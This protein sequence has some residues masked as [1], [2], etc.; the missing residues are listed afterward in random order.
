M[1]T[2][3]GTDGDTTGALVTNI[4]TAEQLT[5]LIQPATDSVDGSLSHLDKAY[6]D[7]LA[8]S[9]AGDALANGLVIST[10]QTPIV[11]FTTTSTTDVV[12]PAIPGKL[13]HLMEARIEF[14]T[15]NASLTGNFVYD[16]TQNDTSILDQTQ[17]VL[18]GV[19]NGVTPPSTVNSTARVSAIQEVDVSVH[20]HQLKIITPAVGSG[21]TDCTGRLVI[22]G[23]F[24]A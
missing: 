11:D 7:A 19:A 8:A 16:I 4:T 5:A 24:D 18:F 1:P 9:I 21:L 12:M 15:R 23:Y 10:Y 14:F 2:I 17:I 13:F 20:C 6:L 22:F 3:K